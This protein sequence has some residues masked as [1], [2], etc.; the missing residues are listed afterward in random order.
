MRR[1][2]I[3]LAIP[4]LAGC[5]FQSPQDLVTPAATGEPQYVGLRLD[6]HGTYRARFTMSFEGQSTWWYRVDLMSDGVIKAYELSMEGLPQ[7]RDPGDVKLIDA[8]GVLTLQG[9]A[10]AGECWRFPASAN[11]SRE[12]LTPDGIIQ[13]ER[14]A[15]GLKRAGQETVLGRTAERYRFERSLKPEFPRADISIWLDSASGGVLRYQFTLEGS[16]PLFGAGEGTL[17]GEFEILDLRAVTIDP[18]EGCESEFPVPDDAWDIYLLSDF[19]GYRTGLSPDELVDF[20]L[21]SLGGQGWQQAAD[22]AAI[23]GTAAL[24][25]RRGATVLEIFIQSE[26][27]WTKVEIFQAPVSGP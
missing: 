12:P 24:S 8:N 4:F 1:F 10:T 26:G 20:M 6:R 16:D 22:T 19:V 15:T 17:T 27:Q 23:P 2:L 7:S 18:I 21:Q 3:L 5:V 9:E 13:P 11:R 25:L 14:I